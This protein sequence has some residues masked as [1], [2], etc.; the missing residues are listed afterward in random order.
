MAKHSQADMVTITMTRGQAECV[1]K[2]FRTFMSK[3]SR[4]RE[5]S[6]WRAL[7]RAL[8]TWKEE[9]STASG[10]QRSSEEHS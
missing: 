6:A 8:G 3:G 2:I 10:P 9:G 1:E 5:F 4:G 7:R